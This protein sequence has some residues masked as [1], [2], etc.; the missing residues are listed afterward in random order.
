M[1]CR[2]GLD[3]NLR[4]PLSVTRRDDFGGKDKENKK[5]KRFSRLKLIKSLSLNPEKIKHP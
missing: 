1:F 4:L 5:N 2:G 3:V